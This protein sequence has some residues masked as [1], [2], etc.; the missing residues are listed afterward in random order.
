MATITAPAP[1]TTKPRFS[2]SAWTMLAAEAI[3]L[4]GILHLVL[5]IEDL[6]EDLLFG[7]LFL[8]IGPVQMLVGA[9][10]VR[11][12]RPAV[13]VV[14][15]LVAIGLI[16]FYVLNR[17][18]VFSTPTTPGTT[19][20]VDIPG[21]IALALELVAFAGLGALLPVG[22]RRW[23]VRTLLLLGLAFWVAWLG[24]TIV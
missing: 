3:F 9:R 17:E 11:G 22:V 5:G 13:S 18:V 1:S 10:V 8:V 20:A 14:S 24:L 2:A 6:G 4:A 23:I 12:V 19:E 15:L 21:T 7:V 16:V